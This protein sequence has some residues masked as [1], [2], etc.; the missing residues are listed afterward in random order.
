ME[1]IRR[2]IVMNWYKISM[3]YDGKIDGV[4]YKKYEDIAVINIVNLLDF[5]EPYMQTPND[6]KEESKLIKQ[7]AEQHNAHYYARPKDD[8]FI[9]MAI[10]ETRE[11][12]KNIVIV[13]N[14]S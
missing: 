4:P 7:W 11:K 2:E 14:M 6:Y 5:L 13:E 10:D 1:K 12:G 8:F 9:T 3:A